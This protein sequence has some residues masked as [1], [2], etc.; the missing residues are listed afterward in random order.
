MKDIEKLFKDSLENHELPYD[1][2]AWKNLE[3]KLPQSRIGKSINFTKWGLIGFAVAALSIS[4]FVVL[5]SEEKQT[6][7][8]ENNKPNH[9][10]KQSRLTKKTI[11]TKSEF[12]TEKIKNNKQLQKKS[13]RN[14][15]NSTVNI[16]QKQVRSNY[17]N[18][19][20]QFIK[21][22]ENV[23]TQNNTNDQT[24]IINSTAENKKSNSNF[25]IPAVSTK[26]QGE[27][28]ELENENSKSIVLKSPSGKL[29]VIQSKS[30]LK[31]NLNQIGTYSLNSIDEK[32]YLIE[33][34]T[35]S[36]IN[37]PSI[38]LSFDSELTY[39]NGLPILKA[40]LESDDNKVK[41]TLNNKTLDFNGKNTLIYAFKKGAY[42]LSTTVTNEQG[43]KSI[44]SKIIQVKDEYNLLAYNAFDPFS[45][46]NRKTTF[47]PVA[48]QNRTSPFEMIIL[49]PTDGGIVFETSDASQPWDGIDRR[50][51]KLV[52]SNKVYIWKVSIKSPEVGEKSEYKGTITRI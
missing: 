31:T 48:L 3:S 12:V 30:V 51:G 14:S 17:E 28:L 40:N 42:E 25:K 34:N 8:I 4:V 29:E 23:V 33:L 5:N 9:V 39:E 21:Y 13:S 10:E 7:L 24:T 47:L 46:D 32:G 2:A 27:T 35:F 6:N 44:E 19:A 37:S 50:D 22:T 11:P 36:V 18:T 1:A 15:F 26:C 49:D 52:N 38:S 41:W 43:C 20:H 45:N 16:E